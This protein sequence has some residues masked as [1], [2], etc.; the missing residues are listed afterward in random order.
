MKIKLLS[1]KEEIEKLKQMYLNHVSMTI[2]SKELNV[3]DKTII[4]KLKEIGIHIPKK[5]CLRRKCKYSLNSNYFEKIDTEDKAYFLG[6]IGADGCVMKDKF[7]RLYLKFHQHEQDIDILEKFLFYL[8]S[9]HVIKRDKDRPHIVSLS[10]S[11]KKLIS[12]L[13]SH[14]IH[15]RKSL[16]YEFNDKIPNH[17]IPHYIRGYMDGDGCVFE[18]KNNRKTEVLHEGYNVIGSQSFMLGFEKYLKQN[19]INVISN[20]CNKG[21]NRQLSIGSFKETELFYDMIYKNSNVKGL[22]KYNKAK[23]YH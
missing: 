1:T 9:N 6:F 13:I 3:S 21:K 17:L 11:D 4:R 23:I 2:I 19:G 8:N 22:R 18:C 20:P 15:F 14:G 7:N 16:T 10:I 12:D 5:T